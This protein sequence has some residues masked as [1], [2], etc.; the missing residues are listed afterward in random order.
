M[1]FSAWIQAHRRSILFLLVV[2]AV[3]GLASSLLLPVSLFP[4]VEFPRVLVSLE[5]GDRPA[6]RMTVEVTPPV[7]EAVRAVPG[8][9]TV[10]S[11]TSRGSGIAS[12]VR[13]AASSRLR[14]MTPVTRS[15][16]AWRGEATKSMP[17]RWMSW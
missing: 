17:R 4:H 14:V 5:A 3:G 12:Y 15:R 1:N 6:E 11:T 10:R 8:V 16:S 2:L 13:R 9:R 7:E